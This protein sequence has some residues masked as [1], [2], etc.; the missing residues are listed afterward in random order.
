MSSS[1][2]VI[3]IGA[4]VLGLSSAAELAARG[5]AVTV[6]DPGGSNA[7]SAAAGMIAP[8][9]ESLIDGLSPDHAALLKR[10]RDLWP[11]FASR[12]GLTLHLDGAEWR[13]ADPDAAVA[14]L[15]ALGFA[16]GRAGEGLFTPDD[17]RIEAQAALGQLSAIP[18][19]TR[20]EATVARLSRADGVWTATADD[21]R[22][23]SA[24]SLV[25]ATGAAAALGGLPDDVTAVVN[26]IEPIRGQLTPIRCAVPAQ[27]IRGPG[28]YATPTADGALCGATMQSGDRSLEPDTEIA[29]KQAAN[30][31]S[32]IGGEGQAGEPRVG[33]RGASPDGLPIAGVTGTPGLFLALAPRRNGWLLG[34]MVGAIVAD[35]I[36]D[37]APLADAS[38]L[39]PLRFVSQP[40]ARSA[41]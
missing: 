11:A 29:A 35:G 6:L 40:A 10:G 18:G 21:S 15:H 28:G 23:W 31:L 16:A 2:D 9:M 30:G 14:R 36:E 25:L 22:E 19:V 4:G 20:V 27:V 3:V 13:G 34:P 37:R 5:H 17:W 7:S 38:A 39:S 24:P 12:H 1:P 41:G 26:A 32:L 33:V 8:A